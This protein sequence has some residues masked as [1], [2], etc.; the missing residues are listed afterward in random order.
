LDSLVGQFADQDL[1]DKVEIVISDNGSQDNTEQTVRE[2]QKIHDNVVYYRNQVNMGFDFNVYNVVEKSKGKYC[3]TLGDD[4]AVING[5]IELVVNFLEKNEVSVLTVNYKECVRREEL[6][7][8]YTKIDQNVIKSFN[9][10]EEYSFGGYCLGILSVLVFD[11]SLWLENAERDRMITGWQYYLPVL[12]ILPQSRL[13]FAYV[14]YPVLLARNGCEWVA[15][16]LELEVY[17]N[18]R[19]LV[20]RMYDFGY[21]KKKLALEEKR[22]SHRILVILLRAKG[23]DLPCT[24]KNFKMIWAEF[25]KQPFLLFMATLVFI[26]PNPVIKIIRNFNKKFI[27]IKI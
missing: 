2:Y 7:S 20:R 1:K 16:G 13:P 15:N 18:L 3:W 12:K 23:H 11:R 6:F 8:D 10:F 24:M 5:G 4:D 17:L 21:D 22:L 14:S 9:S 27:G 19:K 25:I 26:I